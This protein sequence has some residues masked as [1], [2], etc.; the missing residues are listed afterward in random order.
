MAKTSY[1]ACTY[2]E[3]NFE[4]LIKDFI[5]I[6]YLIKMNITKCWI[7]SDNHSQDFCYCK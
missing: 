1:K 2:S 6:L 7:I 5:F 3:D 4:L